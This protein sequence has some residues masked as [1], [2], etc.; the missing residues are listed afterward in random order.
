MQKLLVTLLFLIALYS[1]G[2]YKVYVDGRLTH[3]QSEL[4]WFHKINDDSLFVFQENENVPDSA[5]FINEVT[6]FAPK[7]L[8][9]VRY[10]DNQLA[11]YDASLRPEIISRAKYEAK[12]AGANVIKIIA[13][14]YSLPRGKLVVK[15]YHLKE[16]YISLYKKERDSMNLVLSKKNENYCIVHL[17]SFSP[18]YTR[19]CPIYFNN[20]LVDF[21]PNN[22]RMVNSDYYSENQNSNYN[23]T[24]LNLRF[25]NP[26]NLSI[27]NDTAI[28]SESE[29]SNIMLYRINNKSI[30]NLEKG[31]EYYVHI[32]IERFS[33]GSGFDFKI[34]KNKYEF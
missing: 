24:T 6:L 29:K 8:M 7:I 22:S 32:W 12:Q 4:F 15:L 23:D 1:C 21:C 25:D 11:G 5:F 19:D 16:H 2:S 9:P 3:R 20:T 17:K 18:S 14:R 27:G 31:K 30:I 13:I 10:P 28:Y 33:W 34:L 26:G